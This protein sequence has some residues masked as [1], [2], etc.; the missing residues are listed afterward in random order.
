MIGL[1]DR[2]LAAVI[3]SIGGMLLAGG[4]SS[5][6]V[7]RADIE[8]GVADSLEEQIGQ[9]PA[10]SCEGDL[11][12]EVGS[13]IRCELTADDGSTIGAT[14]ETTDVDGSDIMY[15]VVVDG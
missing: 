5:G 8:Q 13:T 7:S 11:P 15:S 12:G 3:V 2:R 14:V 9:R 4:C 1:I 6:S 10:V